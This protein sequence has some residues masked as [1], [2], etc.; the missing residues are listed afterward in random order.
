MP[1]P[2][3]PAGFPKSGNGLGGAPRR[4]EVFVG[5]TI[6]T[7]VLAINDTSS[8][9]FQVP[10]GF[11]K[12]RLS[13]IGKGSLAISSSV[14]Y[15]GNGGGC[16]ISDIVNVIPGERI[17]YTESNENMALAYSTLI[18]L[19]ITAAK[20]GFSDPV[21]PTGGVKN[22]RGGKG[23]ASSGSSSLDYAGGGAAT[24]QGDGQSAVGDVGGNN[25]PFGAEGRGQGRSTDGKG[26]GFGG[27]AISDPSG[28][29]SAIRGAGVIFI[30][31]WP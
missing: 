5:P 31:L 21:L 7:Y 30:E 14:Y 11:K 25:G 12:L 13:I 26:Y 15:G 4:N 16:S 22:Y 24:L 18:S 8:K 1:N 28:N 17:R 3:L 20:P 29:V 19:N 9:E 23:S 2:N 10:A 6:L 27:Y